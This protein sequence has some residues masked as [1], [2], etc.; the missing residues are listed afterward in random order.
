MTA[1]K[2]KKRKMP[3]T[4]D[5]V[6]D[7][8]MSRH[9]KLRDQW[10][11]LGWVREIK[12]ALIKMR[13]EEGLTQKQLAENAGWKQSFV[14]RLENIPGSGRIAI[15]DI[16]TIKAY[17]DACG[18][19]FG[20][21]FGSISGQTAHI[22]SAIGTSE[23]DRFNSRIAAFSDTDVRVRDGKVIAVEKKHVVV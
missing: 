16:P 19:D 8:Q 12:L 13:R 1:R 10:E 3:E 6:R 22:S 2:S 18:G 15:P 21:V 9:T 5:Q 14:S 4:L 20:L 23:H 17:V 11:A 7:A